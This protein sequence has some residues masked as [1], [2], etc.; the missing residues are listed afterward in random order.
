MHREC[1]VTYLV[2]IETLSYIVKVKKHD[3]SLGIIWNELQIIR[4]CLHCKDFSV[5]SAQR[6][7]RCIVLAS[8]ERLLMEHSLSCL[9]RTSG[10]LRLSITRCFRRTFRFGSEAT[11]CKLVKAHAHTKR[12]KTL[13][14][15]TD[16]YA[17]FTLL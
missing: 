8:C 7:R 1:H 13:Y 10:E 12:C 14:F 11:I 4:L 16:T 2:L 15:S 5:N 17:L 6:G 3:R 9:R